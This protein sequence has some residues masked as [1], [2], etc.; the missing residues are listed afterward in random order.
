LVLTEE[1]MAVEKKANCKIC[2]KEYTY[3]EEWAESMLSEG[4]SPPEYCNEHRKFHA[5]EKSAI[6]MPYFYPVPVVPR[7]PDHELDA[8]RLGKLTHYDRLHRTVETTA[9]FHLPNSDIDFGIKDENFLELKE[10]LDNN[11]VVVVVGPTGSG[12]STFLPYRLLAPPEPIA[13]DYFTR[14]GQIIVTQPRLQATRTIPEFVARDLHGCSLGAGGEIGFIHRGDRS[15]DNHTKL[16]YCTD[17][18]LI[19]WIATGKLSDIGII[20][21][22][23]AHERSLNIDVILGL[24]KLK[25]PL[26]PQLKVIIASATIDTDLFRNYFSEVEKKQIFKILKD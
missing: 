11:Q 21:I 6:A 13:R 24:Q 12:K 15:A 19:N 20:V 10:K 1:N 4:F 2:G 25:L 9:K 22:D 3:S 8:G 18:T 26:Y 14:F 17:G 16:I 5:K 23:E 7:R